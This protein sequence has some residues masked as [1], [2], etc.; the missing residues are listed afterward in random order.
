MRMYPGLALILLAV[1]ISCQYPSK[2]N[3]GAMVPL[4]GFQLYVKD[5]GS[6]GPTVIIENGLAC[7][8]SLYDDLQQRVAKYARVISYDHPGIGRSPAN[9]A[10]RTLENYAKELRSL[11]KS[12]N[13]PPPYILAGHSMGGFMIR[14]Y[15]YLYPR[16][17]AGLVFIDCPHEDWFSYV[18]SRYSGKDL[19]LFN[20]FWDPKKSKFTGGKLAELSYYTV[21]CDSIRGKKIPPSIPVKMYSQNTVNPWWSKKFGYDEKDMKVWAEMQHRVLDG[22]SDARQYTD[23]KAGHLY[24]LDKPREV[25]SGIR[26]L[27]N[28]YRIKSGKKI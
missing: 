4:D 15:A 5:M 26:D 2:D 22:V 8:T 10:P 18:Y 28:K 19:D 25:V 13:I 3:K 27:I 16:E 1:F 20:N 9:S 7:A 21:L 14:Y 24:H 23:R 17:V 11:L 12:K 6:G